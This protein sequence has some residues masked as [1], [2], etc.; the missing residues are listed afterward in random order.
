MPRVLNIGSLNIDYVYAVP[1]F[2]RAGETL[3]ST[4][5]QIFPGGKGLNQSIAVARAGGE[6]THAGMVGDDGDYLIK[7]LR[8]AGVDTGLVVQSSHPTGHTMIQVTPEGENSIILYPGANHQLDEAFIDR[9]LASFG[10][11]DVL[12]L[13]NEVSRIAYAMQSAKAKGMIVA[14]NPSPFS[15]DILRYPLG[16][17]DWWLLNEIE[18]GLLTGQ[19]DPDAILNTMG[20]LYAGSVIILTL[21]K[22]GVLCRF[23]PNTYRHGCYRTHVQDTTAAGDTF[24]G[25]YINAVIK[26]KGIQDALR[27]A[28]IAASVSVSRKGASVSIPHWDEVVNGTHV[29]LA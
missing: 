10:K 15:P 27:L 12:I 25:Y 19:A 24:T 1:H 14:F 7:Q 18:G 13:Q 17:V 26:G 3:S 5:R 2:A 11:G 22:E 21:G 9:A 6:V 28:S 29:P 23:G 16:L 20:T 4:S 8:D